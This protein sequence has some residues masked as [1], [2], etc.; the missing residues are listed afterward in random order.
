M[1]Q[2]VTTTAKPKRCNLSALQNTASGHLGAT[3]PASG[4]II[5]VSSDNSMD[6]NGVGNF[7]CFVKGDGT[8]TASAL[9]IQ[10]LDVITESEKSSIFGGTIGIDNFTLKQNYTYWVTLSTGEFGSSSSNNID[11]Y[12]IVHSLGGKIHVRLGGCNSLGDIMVGFFNTT[13]PSA[14]SLICFANTNNTNTVFET[15]MP[16]PE[17]TQFIIVCNRKINL[18]SPTIEIIVDSLEEKLMNLGGSAKYGKAG[19]TNIALSSGTTLIDGFPVTSGHTYKITSEKVTE[20]A[21]D[22]IVAVGS[23]DECT[24]LISDSNEIWFIPKTSSANCRLYSKSSVSAGNEYNWAI[25]DVTIPNSLPQIQLVVGTYLTPSDVVNNLDSDATNMPMSAAQGKVIGNYLYDKTDYYV[26]KYGTLPT[27]TTAGITFVDGF[28]VTSGHVYKV[29]IKLDA[30]LAVSLTV[31][32][33]S[34]GTFSSISAET[35]KTQ[36]I[37]RTMTA[38]TSA[39]SRIYFQYGSEPVSYPKAE[40]YLYDVTVPTSLP[41]HITSAGL[42]TRLTQMIEN[43]SGGGGSS[44]V[45][46]LYA[47]TLTVGQWTTSGKG[48]SYGVCTNKMVYPYNNMIVDV[49]LP[50]NLACQFITGNN[51]SLSTTSEWLE[52]GDV[53]VFP[54]SNVDAKYATL[55]NNECHYIV[56]FADSTNHSV[57]TKTISDIQD[58]IKSGSISL[59]LRNKNYDLIAA[60]Y[61][62]DRYVRRKLDMTKP[63]IV[64]ISDVHGDR[65]RYSHALDYADSINADIVVNTGDSVV[66]HYTD[67]YNFIV[68]DALK[69]NKPVVTAVGNH[70]MID[71]G[72]TYFYDEITNALKSAYN[73]ESS[74]GVLTSDNNYYVDDDEKEMRYIVIIAYFNGG[75]TQTTVNWFVSAL[76]STPSGYGIVVCMHTADK[77][78]TIDLYDM[79]GN[80]YTSLNLR[81][82]V[83]LY[84]SRGS[85]SVSVNSSVTATCDFTSASGEFICW[86]CGHNHGDRIGHYDDTTN[87][88]VVIM[89][90]CTCAVQGGTLVRNLEGSVQDC[91]NVYQINRTTHKI[92]VMKVGSNKTESDADVTYNELSYV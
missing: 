86:L 53:Y 59:A 36:W 70:D 81:G 78:P 18:A 23:N 34:N 89:G 7:D 40:L 43:S 16:I 75:I 27:K 63:I 65:T 30:A 76:S 73:Y 24:R 44:S 47:E 5:L 38:T 4:E 92:L 72:L 22:V 12:S 85:G 32:L 80:E 28:S 69:H 39:S 68:D 29:R 66:Y 15:T 51:L 74:S 46:T 87:R 62:S 84:I 82:I 49:K 60:V 1:G 42:E 50:S 37:E 54:T 11:T 64:H 3:T 67:G 90:A 31:G 9:D 14:A 61:D 88:Q 35:D 57:C 45:E 71:G 33:G 79:G 91:F 8:H 52:D 55:S 83:D 6:A 17:N 25:E 41:M 21:P 2:I 13:T 19:S 10:S 58:C 77:K 56:N 48:T 20:G 26:Y